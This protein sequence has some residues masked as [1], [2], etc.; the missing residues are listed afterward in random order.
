M[1]NYFRGKPRTLFR[2]MRRGIRHSL[3]V[4]R[5]GTRRRFNRRRLVY[6]DPA[7]IPCIINQAYRAA[8]LFT[9]GDRNL[10]LKI[11]KETCEK[12]TIINEVF[13]AAHFSA[14]IQEIVEKNV[15]TNNLYESVKESNL[16]I[17]ED[18]LPSLNSFMKDAADKFDM[19]VRIA[20]TGNTIDVGANPNFDLRTEIKKIVSKN[21]NRD[22]IEKLR[23]DVTKAKTILYV[24]DNYEEAVFDKF[25]LKE[26]A[27][28]DLTFAVRSKPILND[29]TL[30]DSKNLG[31]DKIC[32]VIE[33]GSNIAGTDLNKCNQE[34]IEKFNNADVV[35]A[36]GQG[37]YE[38]LSDEQRPIYFLFKVK[39]E[40][41]AEHAG[42][43]V[44]SSVIYYNKRVK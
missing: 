39:C 18:Y 33:S 26:L 10:Q 2:L 32:K 40:P 16:K 21:I 36:K 6:F 42:S 30:E 43:A 5:S 13:T 41:I 14:V 11:L 17:V 8:K 28:K 24:G 15:K 1:R 22:S 9:N 35:I 23:E 4:R 3:L 19:A 25:L 38:T 31:I 27:E 20:I 37:N 44:G 29:I 7:C 34:F 12:A